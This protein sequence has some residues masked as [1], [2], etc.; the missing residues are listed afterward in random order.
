MLVVNYFLQLVLTLLDLLLGCSWECCVLRE[1][2]FCS[3]LHIEV[4]VVILPHLLIFGMVTEL[5]ASLT[6][7]MKPRTRDQALR[8]D[9]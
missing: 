5:R 1:R 4:W 9:S 7:Q 8:N 6:L 2:V 3:G